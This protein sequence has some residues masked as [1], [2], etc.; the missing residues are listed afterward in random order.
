MRLTARRCAAEDSHYNPRVPDEATGEL[1][2]ECKHFMTDCALVS[3]YFLGLVL[4][5]VA[6][7]V[8]LYVMCCCTATPVRLSCAF[9]GAWAATYSST[10]IA[11]R[12]LS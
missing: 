6:A 3:L 5:G 8:P 10:R 2:D 4:T 1:P 9:E 7:T 11:V 12:A